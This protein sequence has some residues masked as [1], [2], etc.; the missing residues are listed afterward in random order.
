MVSRPVAITS[1]PSS[2]RNLSR[3]MVRAP[4]HGLDPGA[5][6]LQREIGVAGGMRAAIAG[7]FAAH[8]HIAELRPRPCA[9][10]R[11]RSR[12]PYIRRRCSANRGRRGRSSAD[13]AGSSSARQAYHRGRVWPVFERRLRV[14]AKAGRSNAPLLSASG[15]EML[16]RLSAIWRASAS[17]TSGLPGL[18]AHDADLDVGQGGEA[19]RLAEHAHARPQRAFGQHRDGQA[20]QHGGDDDGCR[21][22]GEQDAVV[23][24]RPDRARRRRSAPPLQ[25]G[26]P[27]ASGS[28]LCSWVA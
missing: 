25:V 27:K 24:A 11:R 19:V 12:R 23:A 1:M 26:R 21:P 18:A 8:P 10:A 5:V 7:D 15:T 13:W 9:S 20:G 28:G 16:S 22:A 6:V 2:G 4:D 17:T 14:A 3:A